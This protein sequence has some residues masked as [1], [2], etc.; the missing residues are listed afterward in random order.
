VSAFRRVLAI[1]LVDAEGDDRVGVVVGREQKV[2]R[3]VECKKSGKPFN[4]E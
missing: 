1:A 4:D 3:W 2:R